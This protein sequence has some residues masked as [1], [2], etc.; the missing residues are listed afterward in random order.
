MSATSVS[1]KVVKVSRRRNAG[2]VTLESQERAKAVIELRTLGWTWDAIAQQ[3]TYRDASGPYRAWQRTIARI[4]QP[5]AEELRRQMERDLDVLKKSMM[6]KA[7]S[8]SVWHVQRVLDCM[9]RLAKLRGLDAPTRRVVEVLSA[10]VVAREIQRLEAE[11]ERDGR[12]FPEQKQAR[13]AIGPGQRPIDVD[14]A[15]TTGT[16]ERIDGRDVRDVRDVDGSDEA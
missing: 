13:A 16:G 11:L 4:P 12:T 2:Q 9:D 1:L 5:A 3:L 6:P 10:D 8:G 15:S 7:L 14:V